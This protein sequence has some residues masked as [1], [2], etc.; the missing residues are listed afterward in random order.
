MNARENHPSFP[1]WPFH[2]CGGSVGI[3]ADNRT[4]AGKLGTILPVLIE[5]LSSGT[6]DRYR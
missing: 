3:L 4:P 1:E 5:R 2:D 6:G